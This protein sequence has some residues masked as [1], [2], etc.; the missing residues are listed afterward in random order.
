MARGK[1]NVF[2][3]EGL[4]TARAAADACHGTFQELTEVL[5]KSCRQLQ[6]RNDNAAIGKG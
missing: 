5:K 3:V 6:E 4:R 1:W 2:S